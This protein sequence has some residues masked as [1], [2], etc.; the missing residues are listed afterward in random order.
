MRNHDIEESKPGRR[1][2]FIQD[3]VSKPVPEYNHPRYLENT[4]FLSNTCFGDA[5]EEKEMFPAESVKVETSETQKWVVHP[6][7]YFD[8]D[9]CDG[10]VRHDA[11]VVG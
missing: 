8:H 3:E 4:K 11:I 10:I 6:M 5:L 7:L 2:G 9:V 1:D